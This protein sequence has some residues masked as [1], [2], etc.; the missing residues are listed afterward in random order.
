MTREQIQH[1]ED[2]KALVDQKYRSG[3]KAH[4]KSDPLMEMNPLQMAENMLDEAIDQVVYCGSLV[5]KLRE[6]AE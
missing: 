6:Q 2:I 1:L 3:A 4:E 5:L